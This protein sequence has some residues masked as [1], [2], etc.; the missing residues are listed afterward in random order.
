MQL[1]AL[2]LPVAW[3][4][5]VHGAHLLMKPVRGEPYATLA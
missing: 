2:H 3:K 5:Y 4:D 1:A